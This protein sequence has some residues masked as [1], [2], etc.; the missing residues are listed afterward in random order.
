MTKTMREAMKVWNERKKQ[1]WWKCFEMVDPI[2]NGFIE[3]VPT[4]EVDVF[5]EVIPNG[6]EI[7][8]MKIA[9]AKAFSSQLQSVFEEIE[10]EVIGKNEK[11]PTFDSAGALKV[12]KE[13]F[14]KLR[15]KRKLE[16]IR[17]KYL[18]KEEK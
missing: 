13:N 1:P 12:I 5:E 18:G 9:V 6:N 15:Q 17:Q 14:R 3:S 7:L 2:V 4:K 8:D 10:K 16:K 11:E